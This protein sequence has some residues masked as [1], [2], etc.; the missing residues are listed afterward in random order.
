MIH[1]FIAGANGGIGKA[2]AYEVAKR[3]A[4]LYL[5]CRNNKK[6]EA[7]A[8]MIRKKTGNED[9]CALHL[10]LASLKS[11]KDFVDNFKGFE[12]TLHI[13]INNGGAHNFL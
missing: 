7:V 13:L 8:R 2:T 5:G 11:I 9:V 10:D 3:G 12:T 4:K 6:G 1:I